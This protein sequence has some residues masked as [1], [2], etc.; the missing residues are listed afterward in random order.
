[1][2]T[3]IQVNKF[4]KDIV[5]HRCHGGF[6]VDGG[7]WR[8][9]DR[10]HAK[11]TNHQTCGCCDHETEVY[12]HSFHGGGKICPNCGVLMCPGGSFIDLNRMTKQDL[13]DWIKADFKIIINK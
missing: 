12:I 3:K 7:S 2:A 5:I 10:V 11:S 1:M 9:G 4:K 8:Q 6:R 13:I